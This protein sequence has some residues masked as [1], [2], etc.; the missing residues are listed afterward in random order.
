L[1]KFCSVCPKQNLDPAVVYHD[2]PSTYFGYSEEKMRCLFPPQRSPTVYVC[3]SIED[4]LESN[5]SS[6]NHFNGKNIITCVALS[7]P[8]SFSNNN[9]DNND[10]STLVLSNNIFELQYISL[11]ESKEVSHSRSKWNSECYTR[12]GGE[13]TF[14]WHQER[15]DHMAM[16]YHGNIAINLPQCSARE[17]HF[18]NCTYVHIKCD[19]S[20]I[21]NWQ[22]RFFRCMGGMTHVICRCNNMPFIPTNTWCEVKRKCIKCN[23]LESFV[24]CSSLCSACLCKKCY[25]ACPIDDVT[26]I[27]LA[28][29]AID[30]GN[31][32]KDNDGTDDDDSI[33]D[34]YLGTHG[35][36]GDDD[37]D[38]ESNGSHD[39]GDVHNNINLFAYD[40]EGDEEVC[41]DPDLLLFNDFDATHEITQD[42]VVQDHGFFTTNAGDSFCD[43]LHHDHMERVSGHVILNQAA[44]CTKRYGRAQISGT[45]QQRHFIQRLA[46]STPDCS[47]PLLYMESSLF[48]WIFYHFSSSDKF[49]I[50]GAL[51]LFAYSINK[52]N[53]FSF[54]SFININRSHITNYGCLTRS[55][56]H[57]IRWLHEVSANKEL[58]NSD[59]HHVS[60]HGFVVDTKS[61]TELSAR[62]KGESALSDSI[63]SHQMVWSLSVSQ[64]HIKFD[65]FCRFTC[66]QKDFP[67]T[68]NLHHW[69]SSKE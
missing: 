33:D 32:C 13:Y 31:V 53:P 9:N 12:H 67:G 66:A 26:T 17:T 63:D 52:R 34:S 37:D 69:K 62:N 2:D 36:Q 48:T 11:F 65:M 8:E 45:Q 27:D 44:V 23:K 21:N 22:Q 35:D 14:W 29:H 40:D 28:D 30:D 5:E 18:S 49:S 41:Y 3:S 50:L 25:D 60:E 51:P 6:I 54:E 16:K 46:S 38:D 68:F 1:K 20:F 56:I 43:V 42:N 61:P 19:N 7:I 15:D 4:V 24:C 47:S 58:C 64:Q 57:Y 55:C 10:E 39:T 59:S